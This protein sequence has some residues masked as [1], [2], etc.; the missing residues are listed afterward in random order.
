VLG[1]VAGALVVWT[2]Q[3]Q[4]LGPHGHAY[5]E[6]IAWLLGLGAGQ[7]I[8]RSARGS[9]RQVGSLLIDLVERTVTVEGRLVRLTPIESTILGMLSEMPGRPVSRE[10]IVQHLFGSTHVGE[11]RAADVHIK[12]LRLKLG[13]DSSS[14]RL[15]VTMRGVGYTL[16]P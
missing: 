15:I 13:D 2:E 5:I 9:T 14:Q 16:R 8:E 12:N 6:R 3:E 10:R 1:V 7:E 4:F 11:S